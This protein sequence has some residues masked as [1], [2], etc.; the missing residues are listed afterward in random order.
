M[1]GGRWELIQ[2]QNKQGSFVVTQDDLRRSTCV[3]GKQSGRK[4]KIKGLENEMRHILTVSNGTY[5]QQLLTV[6]LH[7]RDAP[8]A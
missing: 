3:E 5:M 7:C 8:P 6:R 1:G 4:G 2:A